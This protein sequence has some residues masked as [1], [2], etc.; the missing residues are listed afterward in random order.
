MENPYIWLAV[1]SE[2]QPNNKSK[3]QNSVTN[4]YF[5]LYIYY[6]LRSF[7]LVVFEV[8]VNIKEL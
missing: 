8:F 2:M 6:S 4:R 7:L 5:G 3:F 1:W